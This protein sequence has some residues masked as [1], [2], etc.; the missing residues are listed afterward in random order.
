M[1]HLRRSLRL[2][3]FAA[4][5]S[6]LAVALGGGVPMAGAQTPDA[7]QYLRPQVEK[8]V[9]AAD[10]LIKAGKFQEALEK[11]REAE[12]IA[13]RT[14]YENYFID[15]LRAIA[16]S[17]TGDMAT[18]N[19]SFEA[20]IASQYATP[21]QKTKFME[22]MSINYFKAG[23][24]PKTLV[25]TARYF[26]EGGND[27]QLRQ[28]RIRSLYLTED[29][30]GAAKEIRED[31]GAG[32]KAGVKP[33]ADQLQLLA[34]CY[35]KLKDDTGY[36]FVLDKLLIYYPKKEYWADALRRVQVK[37]DFPESLD[38]DLLRLQQATGTL[39]TAAQY[40]AMAK[41]ARKAGY[42]AEAK[43]VLDE[44]FAAGV[45]GKGA[46]PE[47][48]ALRETVTKQVT[49]DERMLVQNAK[50]AATAKDGTAL[51]NVGY[52]L[53]AAGKYSEGITLIEQGIAKGGIKRMEEA[54][55]H[56]GIAYLAA[57]RKAN[58]IETLRRVEGADGTADLAHLWLILA[59]KP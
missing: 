4:S 16:A 58:A 44:G 7:Q 9:K 56:L 6:L 12:G 49:E 40:M 46:E 27:A 36:A 26:K 50:D 30:A 14:P 18:A 47:A 17:N 8:P 53:V 15:T 1:S 22:A 48:Q 38:L 20:V 41:L 45:L 34:N 37:P 19:R 28:L 31:L 51:V 5:L 59:Q 42:P 23:D 29:Y 39:T 35:I 57:D 32:E 54:R 13:D 25:W 55:L 10:E 24:Y 2:R 33:T 21:A 43:R 11:I 52:A 3:L